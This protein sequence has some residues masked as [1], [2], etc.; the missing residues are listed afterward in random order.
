MSI[1]STLASAIRNSNNEYT[2]RIAEAL[3]NNDAWNGETPT[4]II[5]MIRVREAHRRRPQYNPPYRGMNHIRAI[6]VE[7][8]TPYLS[9]FPETYRRVDQVIEQLP[10]IIGRIKEIQND[11]KQQEIERLEAEK[12]AIDARIKQL[13]EDDAMFKEAKNK[14]HAM[15]EESLDLD[16]KR[17]EPYAIMKFITPPPPPLPEPLPRYEAVRFVDSLLAEPEQSSIPINWDKIAKLI[18]SLNR[19]PFGTPININDF[20]EAE[21]QQLGP[22]LNDWFTEHIEP[23]MNENML[24]FYDIDGENRVGHRVQE[25]ADRLRSMFKNN[26]FFKIDNAYDHINAYDQTIYLNMFDRISFVDFSQAK[27]RPAKYRAV[28]G[29]GF[30]PRKL[31]GHYKLF[32]PILERYQIYAS[33]VDANNKTKKSVNNPCFT[34]A[35][36]QAG[37]DKDTTDKI[38]AYVGF[39]KRINRKQG[40]DICNDAELTVERLPWKLRIVANGSSRHRVTVC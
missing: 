37:I 16:R 18:D 36:Q 3:H 33:Y 14:P 10:R 27:K 32:E 5:D 31:S 30:F 35:L 13:K 11:A 15:D 22:Y 12:A 20:T 26:Q 38:L 40:T 19:K 34:Y 4:R 8:F 25:D 29:D 24:V 23:R 28:H 39:Q 1:A 21:L 9:H 17:N 2:A 7:Y 6:N